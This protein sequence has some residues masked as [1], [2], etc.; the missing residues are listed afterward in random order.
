[1]PANRRVFLSRG[2]IAVGMALGSSP[3]NLLAR[4]AKAAASFATG[5]A[6]HEVLRFV[7]TYGRDPLFVG[8]GVLARSNGIATAAI[9][10]VVRADVADAF[11]GALAKIPFKPVYADGDTL[12]FVA[13]G[14]V[15]ELENLT[16]EEYDSRLA[17]YQAQGGTRFAHEAASYSL[18]QR[19]VRDPLCS[20]SGGVRQLRRTVAETFLTGRV[21]QMLRGLTEAGRYALAPDAE[22]DAFRRRTLNEIP[23]TAEET[24]AVAALILGALAPIGAGVQ[25][26]RLAELAV[27]P[28]TSASFGRHAARGGAQTMT[29]YQ[30]LRP[31]AQ[32]LGIS[33]GALWLATLV[34]PSWPLSGIQPAVTTA[35]YLSHLQTRAAFAEAQQLF[36]TKAPS[37]SS[38]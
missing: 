7:A 20:M 19:Q 32:R 3:L 35:D 36:Q 23:R 25:A 10:L 37:S 26:A 33:S 15:Y 22:F 12:S 2:A 21:S 34:S 30:Q 4:P 38:K 11:A 18:A 24:T 29:R 9:S 1:M 6:D 8:G 31:V 14:T 16:S 5:S 28:L 13:D 17:S 27:S